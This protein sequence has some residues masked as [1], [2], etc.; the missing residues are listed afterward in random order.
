[1]S[2]QRARQTTDLQT[3]NETAPYKDIT[4]RPSTF[5]AATA[6]LIC[7]RLAGGETLTRICKT[8]GMPK[9]QTVHRWRVKFP[10]FDAT[11]TRARVAQAEHWADEI[12]DIA[13][14]SARDTVTKTTPQGRE[15]EAV[16][17]EA[18]Q[19][20]RLM[21]D[22]RK[23]LMAKLAPRIYG[24]KLQHEHS[25][26]VVQRIE[27]S[28]RERMRRLATFLLEDQAAGA[29]IEG[30]TAPTLKP[31]ATGGGVPLPPHESQP[32]ES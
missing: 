32:D 17:N 21:V 2:K 18:I 27:L 26:E 13:D 15:Y 8:P 20:S 9:R 11:Y 25:G 31:E 7:E 30:E 24:D 23:F 22:T 4:G 16:D 5:N 10:G 29:L 1:M 28:D 14:D 3:N 19:R 6:E 12:L